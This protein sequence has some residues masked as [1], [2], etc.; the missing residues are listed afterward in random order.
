MKEISEAELMQRLREANTQVPF[1]ALYR[2]YKHRSHQYRVQGFAILE[3]TNAVGVIYQ[4]Q[5]GQ[6]I[7]YVRPLSQFL[8]KVEVNGKQVPRFK[9]VDATN[10]VPLL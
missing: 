9:L 3:A 7:T 4:A 5:Y 2:H 6:M 10:D 1:G 8:S